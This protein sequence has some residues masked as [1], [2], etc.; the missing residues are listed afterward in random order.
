MT[1]IGVSAVA[2]LAFGP[3]AHAES[4]GTVRAPTQRST[5]PD[6]ASQAGTYDVGNA[7]VLVCS[8]HG[9]RVA[10]PTG[11]GDDLWYRTSDGDYVPGVDVETT[12]GPVAPDCG[13]LDAAGAGPA[14][15]LAAS[16]EDRAIAW[17]NA[18]VGS[19]DYPFACGQF[20]ANA[21]G[22]PGL[23][24]ISALAFHDQ[25]AQA[26]QIHLDGDIPKG[27]LVFSHS[28]WDNVDGV[29]YGH[30]VIARGDGTYVSGGMTASAGVSHTV[31]VLTSWNPSDDAQYLG[32]A[33]APADWP[34]A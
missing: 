18:R 7:V 17:A 30:V 21:Y 1:L 23:G 12:A 14:P 29:S 15:Q 34:G 22:R 9:Q 16:R 28:G 3:P 4:V 32:W 31:Q 24:A 2:A 33:T 11:S 20:V 8:T 26:G 27:A 5:A 19:D 6:L 25:L 13:V 10:G